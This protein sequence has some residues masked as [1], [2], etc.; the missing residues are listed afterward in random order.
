[1]TIPRQTTFHFVIQVLTFI[2]TLGSLG[3]L[4]NIGRWVGRVDTEIEYIKIN[5]HAIENTVNS[6]LMD[7]QI[8]FA[9]INDILSQKKVRN[10]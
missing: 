1:M 6:N 3:M 5:C 9:K 10:Q 2:G 8:E 4:L 7:N